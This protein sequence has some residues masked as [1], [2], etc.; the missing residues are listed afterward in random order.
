MPQTFNLP[1]MI[2]KLLFL[3]CATGL[4]AQNLP[5]SIAVLA[6]TYTTPSNGPEQLSWQGK[7]VIL[8][9]KGNYYVNGGNKTISAK[10]IEKLMQAVN[11]PMSFDE[12]FKALGLD[13]VTI[14]NKPE[15]LLDKDHPWTPAQRA[16]I[17]P[18]LADMENYKVLYEQ[19]FYTGTD[20]QPGIDAR[21]KT[22]L[23]LTIYTNGHANAVTTNKS[24]SGYALPW[25]ST[26]GN[27]NYNPALKQALADVLDG[28][29]YDSKINGKEL[30]RYMADRIVA[31][32]ETRLRE[33]DALTYKSDI[34]NLK[35]TFEVTNARR[36]AGNEY[37]VV[38]HTEDMLPNVRIIF[39]ATAANGRLYTGDS[40]KADYKALISRVQGIT[41][42]ADYLKG[43]PDTN[44]YINY[45]DHAPVNPYIIEEVNKNP[46]LWAKHDKYV[47]ERMAYAVKYPSY[48]KYLDEDIKNS[49]L[50]NCGCD[51]RVEQGFMQKAIFFVMLTPQE[52][53]SSTFSLWMLLPD[54]RVLLYQMNGETL[55]DFRYDA[56]GS[57]S[58][59]VQKPCKVFDLE[60][61]PLD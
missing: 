56:W 26:M 35:D 17:L 25:V 29:A 10:K 36:M 42:I 60:G 20:F 30:T 50:E 48:A 32:N 24:R 1:D 59:G 58:A 8:K 61:K 6:E 49:R 22:Q 12:N 13:T 4:Y 28:T 15:K 31:I 47:E 44:L 51:L 37:Q 53:Q 19:D 45:Y 9:N 7:M 40:L 57:T 14:K 46:K 11:T 33:L 18:L 43:H 39:N 23:T 38:L 41:F 16:Y 34:D 2:R 55:L 21:D 52:N 54:D 5:D 27:E 3:F